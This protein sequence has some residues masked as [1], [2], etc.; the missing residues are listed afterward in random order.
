MAA[1]SVLRCELRLNPLVVD[2][3]SH[4][5]TLIGAAP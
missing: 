2:Y 5:K 3:Q 1:A 4:A